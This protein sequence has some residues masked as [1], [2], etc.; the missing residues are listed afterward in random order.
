MLIGVGPSGT[1]ISID[2][3]Q[4]AKKV[5]L[6]GAKEIANLPKEI[7]MYVGKAHTWL[8]NLNRK[9]EV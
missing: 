4:T 7:D 6:L 1:D 5:S 8:Q 3:L 9:F 2:L